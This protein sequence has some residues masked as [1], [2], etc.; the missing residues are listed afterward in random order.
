MGVCRG[1]GLNK[2]QRAAADAL[3]RPLVPRSRFRARLSASVRPEFHRSGKEV[4]QQQWSLAK[5]RV[6]FLYTL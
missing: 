4:R 1:G 5:Q 2:Y 3:Q 6:N